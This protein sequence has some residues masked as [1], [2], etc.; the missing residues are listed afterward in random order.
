MKTVRPGKIVANDC[1]SVATRIERLS[2][3]YAD[4]HDHALLAQAARLLRDIA[5]RF[6]PRDEG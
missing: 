2:A 3:A 5:T 6:D 1:R 4:S